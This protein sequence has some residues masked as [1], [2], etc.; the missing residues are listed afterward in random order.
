MNPWGAL[1]HEATEAVSR[2]VVERG[3]QAFV[4][5]ATARAVGVTPQALHQSCGSRAEF[6]LIV[7]D[8]L[9]AD[10]R[11]WL[12]AQFTERVAVLPRN[13]EEMARVQVW[14]A[15]LEF[16]EGEARAGHRGLAAL[17][18]RIDEFEFNELVR[19][20]RIASGALPSESG[21]RAAVG[22]VRGLRREI[23]AGRLD[24]RAAERA[25]LG[26]L[27]TGAFALIDVNQPDTA[28]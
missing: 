16:A 10:W 22:M 13:S 18:L 3:P 7:V 2:M 24:V 25:F 8:I 21:A 15:I 5:A 4:M 23:V 6:C 28:A 17:L 9:A 12:S 14:H 1:A 19:R 11:H 27:G 26:S 20:I